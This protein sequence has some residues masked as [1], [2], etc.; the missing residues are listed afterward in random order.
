MLEDMKDKKKEKMCEVKGREKKSMNV[1]AS[2]L[3]IAY[4]D[5]IYKTI[6]I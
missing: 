4:T 3:K 5:G 2:V 1:E 6:H